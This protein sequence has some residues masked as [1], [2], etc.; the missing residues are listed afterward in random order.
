MFFLKQRR[1]RD[2]I[3]VQLQRVATHREH[4]PGDFDVFWLLRAV[5]DGL[6]NGVGLCE[7]D[8]VNIV[9]SI[10]GNI[11]FDM[12]GHPYDLIAREVGLYYYLNGES[13]RAKKMLRKSK[14]AALGTDAPISKFLQ[15]MS[16]FTKTLFSIVK[17]MLDNIFR[18]SRTMVGWIQFCEKILAYPCSRKLRYYSPY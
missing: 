14:S 6:L 1:W 11:R 12:R 16:K 17:A 3:E 13:S 9:D 8:T 4:A 10:I 18:I 15:G 5:N 2:A 7:E